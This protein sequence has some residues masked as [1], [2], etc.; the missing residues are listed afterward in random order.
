[1]SHDCACSAHKLIPVQVVPNLQFISG[2]ASITPCEAEPCSNLM[3]EG[4]E[5]RSDREGRRRRRGQGER[6][7][8]QGEE[9]PR[10]RRDKE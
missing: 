5:V 4:T 10:R 7:K 3:Q 1:M 8:G 6:R 9:G 2:V